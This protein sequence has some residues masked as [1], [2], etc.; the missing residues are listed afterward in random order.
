MENPSAASGSQLKD[1]KRRRDRNMRKPKNSPKSGQ[2]N[3]KSSKKDSQQDTKNGDV[4]KRSSQKRSRPERKITEDSKHSDT[5]LVNV[6]KTTRLSKQCKEQIQ[7]FQHII[8]KENF[9][10]FKKSKNSTSYG[11]SVSSVMDQENFT[12]V[13]NIPF[14]YPSQPLKLEP[15]SAS[16]TAETRTEGDRKLANI[17]NNF[18]SKSREMTSGGAPLTAQL[19]YLITQWS[20]LSDSN[21]KRTDKLY[22][23]FLADITP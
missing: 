5:P 20:K 7:Q 10:V 13:V 6:P 9:K 3:E 21:Y 2:V 11:L 17:L 15:P 23:E 8:G 19:N 4:K 22:K 1:G 18:N 14:S 12:F 16:R